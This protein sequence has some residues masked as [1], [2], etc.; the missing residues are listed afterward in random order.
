[1]S[2]PTKNES[3][4]LWRRWDLHLHTPGTKLN[5]AFGEPTESVWT[6]YIDRLE[7]SPV[8]AFGRELYT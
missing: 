1:M 2:D 7:Q 5:N 8:Q 3:G 4:S 6:H